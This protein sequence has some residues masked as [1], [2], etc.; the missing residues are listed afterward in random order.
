[1]FENVS[2]VMSSLILFNCLFLGL[3]SSKFLD[4]N[5]F[6][7][8]SYYLSLRKT[9]KTMREKRKITK[10]YLMRERRESTL[11]SLKYID[12]LNFI[13]RLD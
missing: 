4:F 7:F 6:Q 5:N 12:I 13:V 11:K 8:F 2:R 9:I 1:M 3:L 10:K